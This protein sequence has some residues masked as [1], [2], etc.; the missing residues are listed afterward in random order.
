MAAKAARA[1]EPLGVKPRGGVAIAALLD[2]VTVDEMAGFAAVVFVVV[3]AKTGGGVFDGVID[4][5]FKV[6]GSILLG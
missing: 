6:G 1:L 4:L 2:D 3:V 5:V